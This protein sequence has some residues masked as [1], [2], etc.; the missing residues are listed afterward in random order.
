MI[1]NLPNINMTTDVFLHLYSHIDKF[2]A[3]KK[4]KI[5]MSVCLL[6]L[7][8]A[9]TYLG[10]LSSRI[11]RQSRDSEFTLKRIKV[12]HKDVGLALCYQRHLLRLQ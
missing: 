7:F 4:E 6:P 5:N 3:Q 9:T 12:T 8:T 10:T 11:A 2:S 1:I